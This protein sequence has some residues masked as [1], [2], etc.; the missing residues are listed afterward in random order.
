MRT[1][2]SF[3]VLV[4]LVITLSPL[5]AYPVHL[6]LENFVDYPFHKLVSHVTLLCGLIFSGFYLKYHQMY[7]RQYFGFGGSKEVFL[8]NLLQGMLAGILI[9]AFLNL[10]L[11]LFGVY[12]IKPN[13]DYFWSNLFLIIIKAILAGLVIGFIEES[14]FRGALFSSLY[15]KTG[16]VVTVTLTS[17][18]YAAVHFLKY[19]ALPEGTEITWVTGMEILP[20]AFFRF[21]D[22]NII[23]HF[24]TLL[25]L[26]VLLSMVRIRNGNIAMCIGIHAG[27]VM[28]MKVTGKFSDYMPGSQFDFLVNRYDHMLGYL[29]FAWL[30]VLATVYWRKFLFTRM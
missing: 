23:D 26:G 17:L 12:Q 13:L 9:L 14:I 19:R 28:T 4:S 20:E 27:I 15:K 24:L 25:V 21:S 2:V 18:V 16:A 30:L 8:G 11:L 10:F 1:V 5:L 7:S 3:F 22:P 29:S 6:I